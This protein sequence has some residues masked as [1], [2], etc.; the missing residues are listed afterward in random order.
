MND[1]RFRRW[2]DGETDV[3]EHILDGKRGHDLPRQD[4][5]RLQREAEEV[6]VVRMGRVIHSERRLFSAWYR[7]AAVLCC[8]VLM[9]VFLYMVAHITRYG[10]ENPRAT[11][12]TERYVEHGLEETGAVNIV[13]GMI[14]DYRAFDTLGE[15]HVLFTALICVMILLRR[16]Q[17][18]MRT[19]YED[20]YRIS[21]EDYFPTDRDQIARRVGGV[22]TPCIL[23]FGIYIL[24][25]GQISPGGGFSGGAVLGAGLVIFAST[26][27]DSAVDR[28]LTKRMFHWA[29]FCALSFYSFAKGYV[30]F[31]GA[32]GLENHIPK[33]VPGAILSGG[34]ILPLDIAV[35]LVVACTMFGFYSL[36][37]RG[38]IAED[39]AAGPV[40]VDNTAGA[41]AGDAATGGTTGIVSGDTA[42]ETVVEDAA[43]NNTAGT[44]A[45]D[46]TT[47][48][49]T[50]TVSGDSAAENVSG[51]TIAD[52]T[53]DKE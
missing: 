44:F 25:N 43:T 34:L 4:Q 38:T 32:N 10:A 49:T 2:L 24:L 20:Y 1:E 13:A 16:D 23:L 46:T 37:R 12:I 29:A 50:G 6:A 52:N 9:V 11:E 53:A 21:E 42:T 30:F 33:G 36:F 19:A 7:V 17:K 15:S 35:G 27:G 28:F 8:L 39:G 45:G 47:G 31:M 40:A 5:R 22:L 26:R 18:N 51:D 41:V 48:G 3:M 14:L